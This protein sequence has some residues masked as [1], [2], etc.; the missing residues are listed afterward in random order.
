MIAR[1]LRFRADSGALFT[2]G[3]YTALKV[4]GE[5]ADHV[6]AFARVHEGT[7]VHHCRNAAPRPSPRDRSCC[8]SRPGKLGRNLHSDAT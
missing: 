3:S 2:E 6:L 7:F 8:G 1:A 4:E 5:R